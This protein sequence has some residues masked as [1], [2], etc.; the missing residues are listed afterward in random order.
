MNNFIRTLIAAGVLSLLATLGLGI[1]RLLSGKNRLRKRCG[2][3]PTDESCS[4]CGKRKKEDCD[5]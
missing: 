1:G 2:M 4:S 5:S 3:L